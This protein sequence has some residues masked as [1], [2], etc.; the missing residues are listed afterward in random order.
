MKSYYFLDFHCVKIL[1]F[2]RVMFII[3]HH[4]ISFYFIT[5][6][7]KA[8]GIRATL[9][10]FPGS[11]RSPKHHSLILTIGGWRLCLAVS[12]PTREGR[13]HKGAAC[14][15]LSADPAGCR[16][17][18]S[19]AGAFSALPTRQ[20]WQSHQSKVPRGAGRQSAKSSIPGTENQQ[21]LDH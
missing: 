7:S 1:P 2:I 8:G 20:Q 4:N 12:L 15:R 3:L 6:W 9:Q 10:S 13:K 5:R 18:A 16:N 21:C 14:V 17:R 19:S 11:N